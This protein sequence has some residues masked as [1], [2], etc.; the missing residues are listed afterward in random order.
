MATLPADEDYARA[1]LTIFQDQPTHTRESLKHDCVR[2][3]FLAHNLGRDADFE[4]AV[5]YAVEQ[6]WFTLELG[7]IRLSK[8]G[9]A[10]M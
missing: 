9:Y 4:A 10:E 3:E 2:A 5:A 1:V 6:G 7:R 8:V